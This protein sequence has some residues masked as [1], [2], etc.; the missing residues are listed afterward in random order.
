V[1]TMTG[2]VELKVVAPGLRDMDVLSETTSRAS[3]LIYPGFPK[4]G[5][6][7]AGDGREGSVS[8]LLSVDDETPEAWLPQ[9][10]ALCS[11]VKVPIESVS[12]GKPSDTT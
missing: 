10:F 12:V 4:G 5:P 1:T 2:Q 11:A 7:V 3:N 8:V 9:L 6:V